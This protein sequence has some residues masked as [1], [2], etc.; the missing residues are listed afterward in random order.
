[1]CYQG[2]VSKHSF[3]VLGSEIIRGVLLPGAH[4]NVTREI[5]KVYFDKHSDPDWTLSVE[6]IL[7]DKQDN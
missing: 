7:I 5:H 1:M 2:R 3:F 6:D 4:G